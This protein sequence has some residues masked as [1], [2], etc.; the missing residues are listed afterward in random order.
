VRKESRR[1]TLFL[2]PPSS[3][4]VQARSANTSVANQRQ[5]SGILE[6]GWTRTRGPLPALTFGREK[7]DDR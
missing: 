4:P 1:K 3:G 5:G 2:L 7:H 6:S